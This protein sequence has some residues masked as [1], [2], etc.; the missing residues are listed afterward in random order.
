MSTLMRLLIAA[1]LLL[2]LAAVPIPAIAAEGSPEDA[3]IF[4]GDYTLENG[5]SLKDLTV[6]G[7]NVELEIGTTVDHITIVG[8]NLTVGGKVEDDI[9]I[10]GGN[11][12]L[13]MTAMVEGDVHVVGGSFDRDEHATIRGE[14]IEGA[15]FNI[16]IPGLPISEGPIF[17]SRSQDMA[18]Q[19][20]GAFSKA[21]GLAILAVLACLAVPQPLARASLAAYTR[22]LEAGG[23]GLLVAILT[24][25]LLIGFTITV[26]GIPITV[27]LALAVAILLAFGWIAL[28]L[29]TGIRLAKAFEQDWPLVVQAGFG[30][31]LLSLVANVIGLA[32]FVGWIIP[33]L[34]GFLGM[35]GVLLSRFG[36]RTAVAETPTVPA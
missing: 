16:H 2:A 31:F 4:G 35:G 5:E 33:A 15:P 34:I 30:T 32:P 14:I 25:V 20:M 13:G 29:E 26:I 18:W 11:L 19:V 21:L 22:P 12:D 1:T 6:L 10:Y 3:T 23:V 24:P 9:H 7:G 28:G 36:T 27:L 8:G 17:I